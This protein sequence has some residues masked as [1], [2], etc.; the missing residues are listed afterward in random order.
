MAGLIAG[1]IVIFF[2]EAIGHKVYP[3]PP[4]IDLNDPEAL[5]RI[6][7][8]APAAALLFVILSWALGSLAG[9]F[10]AS[11]IASASKMNNSLVVGGVLMIL[12][13]INMLMIPHPIWFWI[14]GLLVYIPCAYLG[15]KLGIKLRGNEV[16]KAN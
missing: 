6:I 12:G 5:K 10:I 1:C 14:L 4:N 8:D 2:V 13:I 7:N 16:D 15:G 11:L 9:G 3:P